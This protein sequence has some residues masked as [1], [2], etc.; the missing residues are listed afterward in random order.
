MDNT[1]APGKVLGPGLN[2]WRHVDRDHAEHGLRLHEAEKGQGI[3]C[4]VSCRVRMAKT[5]C[6][7]GCGETQSRNDCCRPANT[8][9]INR[10]AVGQGSLYTSNTFAG[11]GRIDIDTDRGVQVRNGVGDAC[12][13]V[14]KS[15]TPR[16][17][18]S[19]I[20]TWNRLDHVLGDLDL[21]LGDIDRTSVHR[22]KTREV[23]FT[24]VQLLAKC[25]EPIS[26]QNQLRSDLSRDGSNTIET[27]L[28]RSV[29]R[30]EHDT[31]VS[32]SKIRAV[33]AQV[34]SVGLDH[35]HRRHRGRRQEGDQKA[36]EECENPHSGGVLQLS[37]SSSRREP[38]SSVIYIYRREVWCEGEV[39][40]VLQSTSLAPAG[41]GSI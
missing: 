7:G 30:G 34:Q 39:V 8:F 27:E 1:H 4:D 38:G 12:K 18:T 32:C 35:L 36:E 5:G 10:L 17:K 33:L 16:N 37:L 29:L 2:D 3:G 13:S 14:R 24:R 31:K 28:Q 15:I 40:V 11:R 20:L 19:D 22:T 6:D 23:H 41:C 25:G 9:L 21:S 26:I